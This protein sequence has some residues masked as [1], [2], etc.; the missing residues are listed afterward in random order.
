M[1][2]KIYQRIRSSFRK[3]E[4]DTSFLLRIIR[5]FLDIYHNI[6][7]AVSQAGYTSRT[8]AVYFRKQGARIGEHCE[9]QV[10]TLGTEPYLVSIGNRVFISTGVTFHTHDGG[11]WVF[12]DRI[13]DIRVHGTITIEDNCMI[14]RSAHLLPNICI[15]R[16]S[17]VGAGSVVI[18]DV[19]PNSIVMGVPARVISSLSKYEEKSVALWKEQKPPDLRLEEGGHVWWPSKENRRIIRDYLTKLYKDRLEPR[20]SEAD[21]E[22]KTHNR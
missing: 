13:P 12:Q 4:W 3:R 2:G 22:S 14:G 10:R 6:T 1:S 20:D 8:I 21:D 17:I 11:G 9:I 5:C 7:S 19:P 16:N 18:S 15:G